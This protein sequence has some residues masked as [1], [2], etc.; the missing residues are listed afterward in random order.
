MVFLLLRT[1]LPCPSSV[2]VSHVSSLPVPCSSPPGGGRVAL[3]D[4]CRGVA[5]LFRTGTPGVTGGTYVC[6][7]YQSG[8]DRGGRVFESRLVSRM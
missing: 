7:N 5:A 8:S 4:W 2:T 1:S 6:A 3:D